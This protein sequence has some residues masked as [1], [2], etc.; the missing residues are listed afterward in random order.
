[1][2]NN[3]MN[4]EM[5]DETN[6]EDQVANQEANQETNNQE[7]GTGTDEEIV[8]RFEDLIPT[9]NDDKPSKLLKLIWLL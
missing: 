6:Q 3:D 4:D 1:M 5:D 7:T 2:N 8:I 9:I